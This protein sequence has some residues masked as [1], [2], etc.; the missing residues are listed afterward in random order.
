MT[1]FRDALGAAFEFWYAATQPQPFRA[2]FKTWMPE[3]PRV[4]F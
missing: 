1:P 4:D 3:S 2:L